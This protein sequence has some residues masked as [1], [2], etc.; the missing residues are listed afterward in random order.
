LSFNP[1]S[2]CGNDDEY[3]DAKDHAND[4]ADADD[5]IPVLIRDSDVCL[6]CNTKVKKDN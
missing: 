4:A 3:D 1:L 5:I 2:T 6:A